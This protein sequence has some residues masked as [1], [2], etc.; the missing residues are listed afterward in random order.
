[1]TEVVVV[2][3]VRTPI[4]NFGGALKDVPVV[5][6]G[7]LVIKEALKRAGLRPQPSQ[8]LLRYGPASLAGTE[9]TELGE[10]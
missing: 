1:M 10:Q 7:A 4:A 9:M 6:L 8:E 5:E 2:S 3:G